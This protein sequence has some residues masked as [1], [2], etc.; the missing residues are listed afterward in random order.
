MQPLDPDYVEEMSREG[1]D[2]HL[3]LAVFSGDLTKD[4]YDFYAWF[5]NTHG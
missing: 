1:F 3:S 4:E 5:E 2:P